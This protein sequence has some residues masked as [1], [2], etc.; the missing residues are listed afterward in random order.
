MNSF[1]CV[2]KSNGKIRLCLDPRDLN[3]AVK[4]PHYVTPTL[5]DVLSR[6]HGAKYFS[7]LD[8][9]SGYWNLK[10]D[11]K[12]ADLTTFNTVHGRFRFNRLPFGISCAQDEF[13][14]AIDSTFGD[15]PNVL[16]IADDL[17]VVGFAEDGSDHDAALRTVL[18]RA[19]QRGPRF[20]D[21]KLIVRARE[22]PFFGHLIGSN[23]V[24]ADPSK[25]KAITE[26]ESPS[27][28]K[29]LQSFLGMVNYL[30][31]FS[32]RLASITA[33]LRALL[34]NDAHYN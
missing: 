32:P 17:V 23:G 6:L 5:E 33:P 31:R 19:R 3:R 13:Q 25:V 14:R 29:K 26:M 1:V 27:D 16:G 28:A 22:I 24:R 30:N 20:N 11:D 15:I 4:R 8:A 18:E 7:I 34:K 10:L 12:S 2:T 21:E 9:R